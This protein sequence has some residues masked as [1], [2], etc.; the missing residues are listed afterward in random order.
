MDTASLSVNRA[1]FTFV[2]IIYIKIYPLCVLTMSYARLLATMAIAAVLLLTGI[3]VAAD[4]VMNQTNNN[5]AENNANGSSQSISIVPGS[6]N[7]DSDLFYD[8]SPAKVAV[9]RTVIWT[10]DDT[11][12][13]T[14]TS[15]N[16]EKGPSGVFDSG[17][18]NAGKSFTYTFDKVEVIEYYC[19]IHPWMISAVMVQ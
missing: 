2:N 14:V 7:P 4:G 17:M 1:L 3:W 16:P 9:E 18:M 13:H 5:T 10:N 19:V 15:G 11:L 6:G 8:P 12:P